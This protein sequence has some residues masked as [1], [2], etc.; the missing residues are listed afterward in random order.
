VNLRV[1]GLGRR[2]AT[3][4]ELARELEPWIFVS[5]AVLIISGIPMAMSEPLKCFESLLVSDQNRADPPGHRR[6][7][8][9]SAEVDCAG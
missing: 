5:L 1:F 3:V 4:A 2:Y 6:A 9:N 8:Y 7:G